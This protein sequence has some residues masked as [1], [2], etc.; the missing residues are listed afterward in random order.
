[1]NIPPPPPGQPSQAPAR[2][3]R[4]AMS[5]KRGLTAQELEDARVMA[6]LEEKVAGEDGGVAGVLFEDG[7]PGDVGR[8]VREGLG[9]R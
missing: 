9:K 4:R 8:A 6:V 1:M 5:P 3:S 7:V 2:L